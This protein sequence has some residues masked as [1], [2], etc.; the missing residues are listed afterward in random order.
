MSI[1]VIATDD[2]I[3]NDGYEYLTMALAIMHQGP[4]AVNMSQLWLLPATIATIA[5]TLHIG[6]ELAA[7][8][9]STLAF[10]VITVT[11]VLITRELGGER[12]TLIWSAIVI[13]SL[14]YM[15]EGR[16]DILRDHIYWASF[17]LSLL[18]FLRHQTNPSWRLGAAWNISLAIGGLFR[19][20]GLIIMALL[21]LILL[22]DN[23]V[24]LSKRLVSLAQANTLNILIAALFTISVLTD[25]SIFSY[26]IISNQISVITAHTSHV[27]NSIQAGLLEK[28]DILRESLLEPYSKEFDIAA[29]IG[30]IALIIIGKTLTTLTPLHSIL[31]LTARTCIPHNWPKEHKRTIATLFVINLSIIIGFVSYQ[32]FLQARYTMSLSFL[33][34]LPI[35]FILSNLSSS[36]RSMRANSPYPARLFPVVAVIIGIMIIDILT[37]FSP[38]RSYVTD[39]TSW[40]RKNVPLG[41]SVVTNESSFPY[42]A[43]QGL[44]PPNAYR[45]TPK[46]GRLPDH[47][48]LYK[49]F[50][51]THETPRTRCEG[52]YAA[53]RTSKGRMPKKWQSL[54]AQQNGSLLI[55]FANSRNDSIQIYKIEQKEP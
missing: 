55:E 8:L 35:P 13:L 1:W 37:S 45:F 25:I 19:T 28:A 23:R 24:P 51:F 48:R 7:Y 30:I 47:A 29:I 27:I 44:L 38:S 39:A 53:I 50:F 10:I 22:L 21:P 54:I 11:F 36:W 49:K 6:P 52:N 26:E 16:S 2:L 33:L 18:L 20:E 42:Y 32:F 4:T 34:L 40:F 3:N 17:L 5:S 46:F 9:L 15:N 12:H 41:C 43:N 14:P 31:L